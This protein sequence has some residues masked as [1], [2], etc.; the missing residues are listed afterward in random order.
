MTSS[1]LMSL[2]LTSSHWDQCN[3]F[4]LIFGTCQRLISNFS[5]TNRCRYGHN[6]ETVWER[7][8]TSRRIFGD[9]LQLNGDWSVSSWRLIIDK[10]NAYKNAAMQD[11]IICLQVIKTL[12]VGQL[13]RLQ[14]I[15]QNAI[16][17]SDERRREARRPQLGDVFSEFLW[18][19]AQTGRWH[20]ANPAA[21]QWS[22]HA[23]KPLSN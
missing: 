19:N 4:M 13:L 22:G 16:V 20:I 17:F 6:L 14:R 11:W 5:A 8:V 7:L 10:I 2:W 23:R 1:Q 12:T 15:Y 3:Q 18:Y 21:N 9:W